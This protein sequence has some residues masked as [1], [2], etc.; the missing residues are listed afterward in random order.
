LLTKNPEKLT[1]FVAVFHHTP[2]KLESLCKKHPIKQLVPL[3]LKVHGV[4]TIEVVDHSTC[5]V[6]EHNS[7]NY[8]MYR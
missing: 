7:N 5:K 6:G 4:G 2:M 3:N 8:M 1:I